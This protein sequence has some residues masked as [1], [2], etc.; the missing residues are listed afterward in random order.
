LKDQNE[1]LL[2][3]E[4]RNKKTENKQINSFIASSL[5]EIA[6]CALVLY[7]QIGIHTQFQVE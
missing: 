6:G 3:D 4:K 7:W 5:S 2:L 1:D